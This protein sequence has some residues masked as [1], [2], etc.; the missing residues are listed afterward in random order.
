[1]VNPSTRATNLRPAI[2]G[3]GKAVRAANNNGGRR[4]TVRLPLAPT[5][6]ISEIEVV[7]ALLAQLEAAAANDNLPETS[8]EW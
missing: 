8:G 1:M 4:V 2:A 6:S 5:I 3:R 7:G